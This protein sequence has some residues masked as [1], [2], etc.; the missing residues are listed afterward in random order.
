LGFCAFGF[1]T[2]LGGD[3]LIFICMLSAAVAVG[4]CL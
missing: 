4:W 3:W 1:E 2:A